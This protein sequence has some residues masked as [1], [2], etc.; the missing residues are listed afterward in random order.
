M[1]LQPPE[2]ATPKNGGSDPGQDK[3]IP[4]NGSAGFL[5][6]YGIE[7]AGKFIAFILAVFLQ[8]WS[9][10]IDRWCCLNYRTAHDRFPQAIDGDFR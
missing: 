1:L 8:I 3:A 9:R 10:F 2:V 5:G 7:Y 4:Q 6:V